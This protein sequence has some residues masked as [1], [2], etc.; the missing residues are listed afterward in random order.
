MNFHLRLWALML[1]VVLAGIGCGSGAL[2][3]AVWGLAMAGVSRAQG[4]CYASCYPGTTCNRKTG[5][6]DP[7]PCRGECLPHEQCVEEGLSSRCVAG[8]QPMP[9]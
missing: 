2:G 6:C 3:G 1:S 7:L 9:R 8:R 4:G 5:Y